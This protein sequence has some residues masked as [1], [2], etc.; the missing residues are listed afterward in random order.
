M[1][2]AFNKF[3]SLF[4]I[5]LPIIGKGSVAGEGTSLSNLEEPELDYGE[6][7]K[8]KVR[9]KKYVNRGQVDHMGYCIIIVEWLYR[10]RVVY[11]K[12]CL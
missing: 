11:I 2:K 4:P 5:S 7:R 12:G 10:A 6:R 1:A 9:F 3:F 8:Y